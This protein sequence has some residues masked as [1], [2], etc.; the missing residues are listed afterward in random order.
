MLYQTPN[1]HGGDIFTDN[2]EFDFSASIN[3][4]GTPPKVLEAM[5]SALERSAVYPDPY[6]RRAIHAVSVHEKLP[7]EF[8]LMGNGAAELIY[9]YCS[10]ISPA[11]ALLFS[12]TFSEYE[13]ALKNC[14]STVIRHELAAG[15]GF[16]PDDSFLTSIQKHHPDAVFL[17]NPNNPTGLLIDPGLL[18]RMITLCGK[19]D[20]RLFIDECFLDL[21]E[22][23]EST[24][25]F[26]RNCPNLFI[27]K[28]FTKTYALAGIRIGYGMT[29]DRELLRKMSDCSQPWNVSVIAQAAAEA[30]LLEA[31]YLRKSRELI[32]REREWLSGRLKDLH[33]SPLPSDANFLLFR[34]PSDL[35]EK[36]REKGISV[37]DCSNFAGL[38]KGWYRTAVRQHD[39]NEKLISALTQVLKERA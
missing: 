19:E 10:S 35:A 20:I 24:A 1:P 17:C 8:I 39:E 28:A 12:P 22:N 33:L 21:S 27:L 2:I 11:K 36:L 25:G 23:G 30:A 14:K 9:A 37:R 29:S 5:K 26:V 32:G 18:E 38:E 3:P 4:L 6:C 16:R 13:T 34:G 15:N 31:K 7:E